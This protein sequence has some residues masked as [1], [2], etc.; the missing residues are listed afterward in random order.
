MVRNIQK[1]SIVLNPPNIFTTQVILGCFIF[2]T[3]YLIFS[4]KKALG[5]VAEIS[6]VFIEASGN[7]KY[8]AKIKAHEQGMTRAFFL[9]ADKFG[10]KNSDIQEAPFDRLR[11]V[12]KPVKLIKE[13][14]TIDKYNATVTYEYD[15]AKL[16]KLLVDYGN[17]TVN[18][19]FYE[20]L[21]LP[22]FKQ[23][24]V[25]NIWDKDKRWNDFWDEARPLLEKNKILYPTKTLLISKKITPE[26][27]FNLTYEEL[28]EI[29]PKFLFKK[30]IIVTNEYFTNRKTGESFMRVN[31]YILDNN[32]IANSKVE[33]EY[34][35]YSIDDISNS[36]HLVINKFVNSY[37]ALRKQS[38][39]KN[40]VEAQNEEEELRPIVMNFDVF[41]QEE[42]D[43][44]VSKL[45]KVKQIDKF[46]IKNDY[47][48][49]YKI[50]IYTN[51]SEYELAEGLY[52]NG[53]SY[54]IHGNLYNL[55]DV[56]KPG[57]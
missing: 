48:T 22:V 3:F 53:L 1:K 29:F 6:E 50:L 28:I 25:L 41:D 47:E 44:V 39:I 15:R 16:Y 42:M 26:N 13:L 7:N 43:L 45:K 9:V 12:F 20:C 17:D 37:G 32:M 10:I 55:I 33:N 51:A 24:E 31:S 56:K 21:V 36:V 35:L 19:M 4:P 46:T 34:K 49:R 57:G 14:N 30:G 18:N 54:K 52:T 38:A 23:G 27:L 8:E 40:N 11:E 5:A 2:L